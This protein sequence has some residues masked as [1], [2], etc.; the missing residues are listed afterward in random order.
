V[1]AKLHCALPRGITYNQDV[2]ISRRS[3][4]NIASVIGVIKSFA[5]QPYTKINN[6]NYFTH[7]DAGYSESVGY[8][9]WVLLP[10]MGL[11]FFT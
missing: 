10:G 11:A 8:M 7:T 9:L 5:F 2:K 1:R 6:R 4:S 3:L